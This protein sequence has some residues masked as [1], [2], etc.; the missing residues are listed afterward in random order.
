MSIHS[1]PFVSSASSHPLF[2]PEDLQEAIF[3]LQRTQLFN[4]Q[5]L[6]SLLDNTEHVRNLKEILSVLEEVNDLNHNT[7]NALLNNVEHAEI[8]KEACAYLYT[9]LALEEQTFVIL[10]EHPNWA[11]GFAK[12]MASLADS[13]AL[14]D[15]TYEIL[16]QNLENAETLG[17]GL[18][19]LW[20][21]GIL[22]GENTDLL[23]TD[24]KNA[25]ELGMGLFSLE[26]A[27][28]MTEYRDA[29]VQQSRTIKAFG[30]GLFSL[31]ESENLTEKNLQILLS[32]NGAHAQALVTFCQNQETLTE[33]LPSL[34]QQSFDN[35][36]MT[37]WEDARN[38]ATALA[39]HHKTHP[40]QA[41]PQDL[42]LKIAQELLPDYS[43]DAPEV[44]SETLQ[45][46]ES[47]I[48]NI[49][50]PNQNKRSHNEMY[51]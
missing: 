9:A 40:E 45:Y 30:L 7:L 11:I 33:T 15:H 21:G 50:T 41:L 29:F 3:S 43:Q 10:T 14:T 24:P 25:E 26:Q 46:L 28:L 32:G 20:E 17:L 13:N 47:C 36:M 1:I 19:F 23:L 16:T 2:Y 6:A 49:L 37:V 44:L 27:N 4:N 35:L 22:T 42:I 34:D 38:T 12:G 48:Q 51:S 5:T 39:Q 8:L 18:A 31:S